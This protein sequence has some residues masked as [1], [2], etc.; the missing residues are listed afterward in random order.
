MQRQR[1]AMYMLGWTS[2]SWAGVGTLRDKKIAVWSWYTEGRAGC[3]LELVGWRDG[4]PVTACPGCSEVIDETGLPTGG[5]P[6]TRFPIRKSHW[7]Q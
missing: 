4:V 5:T 6:G 1:L 2:R 3:G 7:G